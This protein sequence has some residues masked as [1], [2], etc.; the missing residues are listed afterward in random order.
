MSINHVALTYA[1]TPRLVHCAALIGSEFL[2]L[3]CKDNSDR[4]NEVSGLS[5]VRDE[6]KFGQMDMDKGWPHRV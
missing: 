6:K 4:L 5:L 3:R 2:L 1:S